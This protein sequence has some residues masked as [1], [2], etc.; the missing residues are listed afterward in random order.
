MLLLYILSTA[1][2]MKLV[3]WKKLPD[4]IVNDNR[5]S[6]WAMGSQVDQKLAVDKT[7][8][9]EWFKISQVKVTTK[10]ECNPRKATSVSWLYLM[11][12]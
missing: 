12:L 3:H 9:V 6:L 2:T 11:H 1:T 4:S 7:Q 10:K 8:I 5:L